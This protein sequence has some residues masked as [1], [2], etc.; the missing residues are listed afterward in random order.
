VKTQ[1]SR[2]LFRSPL[3]VTILAVAILFGVTIAS[4]AYMQH[5][6]PNAATQ[7]ATVVQFAGN[8]LYGNAR[9]S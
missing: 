8:A 5:A 4:I 9:T 6:A 2:T 7:A 3:I 1:L